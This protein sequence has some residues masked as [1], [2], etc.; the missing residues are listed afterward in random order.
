MVSSWDDLNLGSYTTKEGFIRGGR[1]GPEWEANG[2]HLK[3]KIKEW[4]KNVNKAISI[5]SKYNLTDKDAKLVRFY[6]TRSGNDFDENKSNYNEDNHCIYGVLCFKDKDKNDAY[7]LTLEEPW[8]GNRNYVSCIPSGTYKLH[9]RKETPAR[10]YNHYQ[11][12]PSGYNISK[13]K[14]AWGIDK[15]GLIINIAPSNKLENIKIR[16]GTDGGE[17]YKRTGILIHAGKYPKDIE[18]CILLGEY[19]GNKDGV[20]CINPDDSTIALLQEFQH[21]KI[22]TLQITDVFANDRHIPIYEGIS[23]VAKAIAPSANDTG[24]ALNA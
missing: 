13:D 19:I 9:K 15:E 5:I 2:K 12:F 16:Y 22:E 7:Y 4:K 23:T 6:D 8:W 14:V 21:A 11:L 1:G 10:E 24:E 17:V 18:G 20:Y 3:A